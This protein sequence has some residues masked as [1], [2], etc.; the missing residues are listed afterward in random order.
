MGFRVLLIGSFI[1]SK[2]LLLIDYIMVINR[3]TGFQNNKITNFF[4]GN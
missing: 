4:S 1:N 3:Y 2:C